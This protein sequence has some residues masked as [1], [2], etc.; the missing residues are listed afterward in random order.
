MQITSGDQLA[1]A[2]VTEPGL[3]LGHAPHV[4]GHNTEGNAFNTPSDNSI[5]TLCPQN[6]L[7]LAHLK[8]SAVPSHNGMVIVVLAVVVVT[9][10]VVA[11]VVVVVIVVDVN[12][13]VV[14]VVV[15]D[16]HALHNAG[17]VVAKRRARVT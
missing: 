2:V 6:C 3:G 11:V 5:C 4:A 8:S 13:D 10:V 9:V 12:V 1:G 7:M 16:G 17:H 15:V 14:A